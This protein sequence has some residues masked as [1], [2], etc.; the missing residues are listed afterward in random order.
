M[1]KCAQLGDSVKNNFINNIFVGYKN[2][3]YYDCAK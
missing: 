3:G 1:S 2:V